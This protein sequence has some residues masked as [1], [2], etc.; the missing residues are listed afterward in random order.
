MV[1]P[2]IG[3]VSIKPTGLTADLDLAERTHDHSGNVTTASTLI[4][5]ANKYRSALWIV[6]DSDATI[7]L[8]LGWGAILH[9]GLRLNASGGSLEINKSNLFKGDAF[10]IHGGTGSKVLTITELE[11]RYANI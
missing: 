11:S 10:A 5:R 7:Y 6:N 4:V 1:N 2:Y 9:K 8:G 3:E